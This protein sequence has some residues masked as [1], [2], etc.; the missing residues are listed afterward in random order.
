MQGS[1]LSLKFNATWV[2]LL[3]NDIYFKI[4][5]GFNSILDPEEADNI[6]SIKNKQVLLRQNSAYKSYLA[7][8]QPA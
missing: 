1:I 3:L 7:G 4:D 5:L 8:A 6:A 2:S